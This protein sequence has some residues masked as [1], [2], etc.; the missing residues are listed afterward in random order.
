[1]CGEPPLPGLMEQ[2]LALHEVAWNPKGAPVGKVADVAELDDDTLILSDQG[3]LVFTGGV[4]LASDAA[5]RDFRAAAVLPAGDKTGKWLVTLD[6]DG[7]MRRLRSRSS[8]E[9]I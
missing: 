1:G 8:L 7:G 5:V 4:L 3:A 2:P 9:E 6:K